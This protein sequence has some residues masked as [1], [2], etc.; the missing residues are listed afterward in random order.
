MVPELLVADL[1]RSLAFYVDVLGFEVRFRR[2]DP[3]FVY[4]ALGGA[5]LMLE[6][7]HE[8]AWV[9]GPLDAPRGRGVNLQIEVP[10]A[11]ALRDAV[12]ATGHGLFR[13]IRDTWYGT[14]DGDG[15]EGQREF[16][17][18]DPDG[19]LLRFAQPLP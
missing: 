1:P 13:E 19:Y 16:L 6:T 4:L 14:G 17:V 10:D 7:D 11:R 3:D 2:R 12:V 8:T 18:Q 5:Q 9:A 15:D